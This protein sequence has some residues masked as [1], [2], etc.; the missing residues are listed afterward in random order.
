MPGSG[1]TTIAKLLAKKIHMKFYSIGDLR[2]KMA[3]ERGLTIDQLNEM[4]MKEA[5][6]DTKA[7]D[8]QKRL[9]KKEDNFVIE[10]RLGFHFIPDSF[11][12][13]LDVDDVTAA[14]RIMGDRRPDEERRNTLEESLESIKKR[15]ESDRRRYKKYYNVDFEDR[16]HYDI[17]ID[18]TNLSPAQVVDRIVGEIK[19][20]GK[21]VK[22]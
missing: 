20:M 4:G 14:K 6:T 8:Y 2:G 13:F 9:G 19:R 18:T 7:D 15:M 22:K 5:W 10:S 16:S 1:K 11:K 21:R 12:V 3:L 17:V